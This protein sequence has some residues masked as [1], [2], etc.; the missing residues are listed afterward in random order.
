MALTPRKRGTVR[1]RSAY[2]QSVPK[3]RYNEN[4]GQKNSSMGRWDWGVR[5][6]CYPQSWWIGQRSHRATGV[7]EECRH[8]AAGSDWGGGP[9][10]K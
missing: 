9:Y 8:W 10:F 2:A 5:T 7:A 1:W 4:W 6:I 3:G